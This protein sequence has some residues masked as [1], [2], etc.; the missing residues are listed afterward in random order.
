MTSI[1]LQHATRVERLTGWLEDSKLDCALVLGPD[2]VNHLAGYWRYFGGPAA[3]VVGPAGERTLIVALDEAPIARELSSADHVIPYGQ[4]GF[5]LDLDPIGSLLPVVAAVPALAAARRIGF[6]SELPGV[7]ERV[8][9]STSAELVSAV[10]ELA[11]IRLRKDEDEL[12][13]I[14]ASYDLCW[15][16]QGA[17]AQKAV[18]GVNEIELFAAAYS[19]ALIAAGTPIEL[20][21]DLLSGPNAAEVCGPI[22]IPGRRAVMDGEGVIAD[23]V[24]RSGG[25]W[26]D[27]AETHPVGDA[28]DV[29]AARDELFGLLEL[30][31]RQL[32]P[33]ET[34]AGIFD[35]IRR[36][37]ETAFPAGEF[38][39]HGGHGVG[40]SSFEDPHV[41]PTDVTP[42]EAGM[43]IALEPGVYFANRFGARVEQLY[44]V[45]DHGGVE[46][47]RTRD[48]HDGRVR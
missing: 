31:A 12:E 44:L 23:M 10:S 46:L 28:T 37:I 4:R 6:A 24:V 7:G 45:T 25:Y 32:V 13:R 14:G 17:I 48:G 15:T 40:L 8:A 21:G 43:V 38:P 9:N 20:V 41:I 18:A 33:G 47:R 36:G 34:G 27:T 29:R 5:G 26:G 3:V 11:R 39:H 19:A 2:H 1:T 42:L 16:A 35:A 22:R 30:A